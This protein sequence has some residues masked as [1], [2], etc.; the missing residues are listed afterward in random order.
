[1][2]ALIP[3]LLAATLATGRLPVE[4][5]TT[6]Q[7]LVS[8]RVTHITRSSHGFLWIG[9][10]DGL[11]RYDGQTF[12]NYTQRDGLPHPFVTTVIESRDGDIYVATLRGLVR[13]DASATRERGV[14]TRIAFDGGIND[15]VED[16]A[17]TLWVGCGASLCTVQ[18][19]RLVRD[20]AYPGPEPRVLAPSRDGTLWA[21]TT[22]GLFRRGAN[23]SW[24]RFAIQPHR[25]ADQVE[26]LAI[27]EAG[28]L[29]ISNGFGVFV[30]DVATL[31]RSGT[32]AERVTRTYRPGDRLQV[33]GFLRL[34]SPAHPVVVARTA[35]STRDGA[36][37]I[38]S[39]IGVVRIRENE[40]ELL[41]ERAGIRGAVNV[42]SEDAAGNLWLGS[43]VRGALRVS[44]DGATMFTRDHGLQH[45][46]INQIFD[47]NGA[48]CATSGSTRYLQCFENGSLVATELIPPSIEFAGWGWGDVVARDRAGAWWVATGQGVVHWP[49]VSSIRDFTRTRPTI[50]DTRHGLGGDDVFRIF[51]DSRGDLWFATF[52]P[53]VLT[54]RSGG[55]F[56]AYTEKDGMPQVAPTAFAEDR[57]G[58]L[59]IGLYTGGLLCFD[60][61]RFERLG[62]EARIPRGFVRD[63]LVDHRGALWIATNEGVA[64]IDDPTAAM[65]RATSVR[66]EGALSL[67][68]L[69]AQTIVI[70]SARGA[71][72]YDRLSKRGVT[73]T[74]RDGLPQNE[75][76]VM[77]RDR[78]GD[79]WLGTVTGLARRSSTP[80]AAALPPPRPRIVSVGGRA[81]EE[82][83]THD[84]GILRLSWPDHRMSV[85]YAAADFDVRGPLQFEYRLSG[86][87]S[88]TPAGTRR[89]VTYE[90][91]PF[92][93]HH[94]EVRSV[95]RDG[96]RSAAATMYL[97]VVPPVWRRW[98]FLTLIALALLG[99]IVALHRL[100]VA[101]LLALQQMRMRVAT[102]LHD[103]LGSSLS[104]ISILTE[105]AKRKREER[106]LDEI[107]DT[108]RGL[109]DALGD[110]IW[111]IDP[112]R[113]DLQS[114]MSRVRHFAADVLEA[115]SIVLD[116]EA[117]PS[118]AGLHLT[119]EKR[120][121]VFLILKEAIH[122]AAR[123]SSAT[124]VRVRAEVEGSRVRISV[125]DDGVG[126]H[127]P[128]E[129]GHGLSSMRARAARA[130]GMLR[131]DGP[132]GAGTR[133][134]VTLPI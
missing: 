74:T 79:L 109:V 71:Q 66:D 24:E 76:V 20:S 72:L 90:R 49:A 3:F 61:K 27:D 14:F 52:G 57:A 129:E 103:D 93:E 60:G 114:V 63:L 38:P 82:L 10:Q 130:G 34:T 26:G 32:L 54:R 40:I 134:D 23:G 8:D 119:P 100:R 113:D 33:P 59:W 46:R 96:R 88:W 98:W 12:V 19:D 6:A 73:L 39:A 22:H 120:R 122:N 77:H 28:R 64:R 1:V 17:G 107:G 42:V 21:G 70:G 121:E 67:A 37:W 115:K 25:G 2:F 128:R 92:G 124:R 80:P 123:H 131:I 78:E 91:L 69:D 108:A 127:G 51:A 18:G 7:G 86:D 45:E 48:V 95:G 83:G 35:Y 16:R 133:I 31:P 4:P 84:A 30:C 94:F 87:A 85:A 53:S 112:R 11:S 104:R 106:I 9:T 5:I 102:D 47:W 81:T 68:E 13:M 43:E 99:L 126:I 110:T 50:Y 117:Q 125:M 55:V 65:V 116:F 97:D 105:L 89:F 44:P 118:L 15:I 29:W 111:A 62:E 58:N 56:Q 75:I 101:R 36:M 41:G 132:P